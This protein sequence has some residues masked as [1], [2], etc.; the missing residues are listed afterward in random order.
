MRLCQ[1]RVTVTGTR[2]WPLR[3]PKAHCQG[4]FWS[5]SSPGYLWGRLTW[6]SLHELVHCIRH[7]A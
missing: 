3:S 4:P 6:R 2:F 5:L 7:G 1:L